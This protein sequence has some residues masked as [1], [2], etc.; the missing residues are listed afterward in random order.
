VQAIARDPGAIWELLRR[1]ALRADELRK[2]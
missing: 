1:E 2:Q